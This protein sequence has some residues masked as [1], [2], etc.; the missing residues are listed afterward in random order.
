VRGHKLEYLLSLTYLE[1]VFFQ[2][3]RIE[4]Y[5]EEKLKWTSILSEVFG[6]GEQ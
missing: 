2:R 1:K 3:A 5:N 6:G 4:H